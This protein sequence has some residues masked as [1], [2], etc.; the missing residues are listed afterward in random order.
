MNLQMPMRP[1]VG[2]P[3]GESSMAWNDY[4]VLGLNSDIAMIDREPGVWRIHWETDG[5]FR[6]FGERS[7][8][9]N[10][11]IIYLYILYTMLIIIMY[12]IFLRCQMFQFLRSNF[13]RMFHRIIDL[14]RC[15]INIDRLKLYWN[16]F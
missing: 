14:K 1:I 10:C 12:Y 13:V 11:I 2:L 5:R 7:C 15:C 9:K 6:Y 3:K 16:Y 4:F 8:V